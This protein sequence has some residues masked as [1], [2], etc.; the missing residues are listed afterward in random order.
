MYN[1]P[2]FNILVQQLE[3]KFISTQIIT[4]AVRVYGFHV[5][6]NILRGQH[7]QLHC[8][9]TWLVMNMPTDRHETN[10]GEKAI[11]VNEFCQM[12][13][14]WGNCDSCNM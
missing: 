4:G 12:F 13:H 9:G 3:P 8:V 11:I 10:T 6:L 1:G 2:S 7:A 5:F 14:S